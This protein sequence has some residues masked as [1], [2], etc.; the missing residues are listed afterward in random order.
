MIAILKRDGVKR[1]SIELEDHEVLHFYNDRTGDEFFVSWGVDGLTVEPLRGR[2]LEAESPDGD[3]ILVREARDQ[4][5]REG[6]EERD[7]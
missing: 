6:S 2:A 5:A 1:I 3:Y 4:A 7:G